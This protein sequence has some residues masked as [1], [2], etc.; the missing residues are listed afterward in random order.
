MTFAANNTMTVLPGPRIEVTDMSEKSAGDPDRDATGGAVVRRELFERLNRAGRVTVVSGPAGSGKSVL[1]RSWID[2]AALAE[3]AAQLSVLDED[4]DPQ[5][6]WTSVADA[7]RNTAAGS[8]LISP[9][10]AA[11]DLDGWAVVERL[12]AD[13]GPLRDRI[14]LVIDDVHALGSAETL[15]QFELL[16]MR[17]PAGLRFV[18]AT[19]HDL[20]L[21]LHR[22]RLEGELTE[23]RA[24]SLR[25]SRD[26][27]EALFEAAGVRLSESALALLHERTEGWA[28][29]LRLAV[30]SLTGHPDP[31]RFA[32]E[33]CGSE[34]TVAEYLLAEVLERQSD[35]VRRLLSRTSVLERVSGPL[36]DLLTGGSG[37]GQILQELEQAGAFVVALDARRSWFRYHRL[38]ADLLELELRHTEPAELAALHDTAADWFAGHGFPVEAVR[39]AQAAQDWE[40]AGHL[41]ADHWLDVTL[42]GQAATAHQLVASFPADAVTANAELTAVTAAVELMDGSL[43]EGARYLALATAGAASVP[44]ARRDR[45]RVTLAVLRVYLARQR[46]DLRAIAEEVE[47]LRSV[48]D[49]DAAQLGLGEELR[50]VALISLGIAELWSLQVDEAEAHLERGVALARRI[51]RPFLEIK[52]L[53][54]W[55]VAASFR[56]S[57]LAAERSRQAIELARRHGWSG[58]PVVAIAYPMLAGSL[59]WQGELDEAER[60]LMEGGYALKSEVE[61]ATEMLFQLVRGLLEI[62]RGHLEAAL[63]TLRAPRRLPGRP[64]SA[65]HPLTTEVRAFLLDVL[66]RLG[67]PAQADAV[68]IET[69]GEERER[70]GIRT[71]MAALRLAQDDPRAA[72]AALAPVLDGSA[73]GSHQV[74]QIAAFLLEASARDALGE[75]EAAGRALER[76]LDLAEPAGLLFPFLL[77]P[78]PELLERHARQRTAHPALI[79]KIISA[80]GGRTPAVPAAGPPEQA[81]PAAGPPQH[82]PEPLSQAEAR[83]LRLLQTSLSAPEIARELYV[84]VNTVRT[85]MRHVYDKLGAHRRLEA[86][87]R[88]RALGLLAVPQ[89]A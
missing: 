35:E 20:R 32:A 31:E 8:A 2:E 72:T 38:F 76:G 64:L 15:R 78:M 86:I 28:A 45:L 63:A 5:R 30:L 24:A 55:G 12:L 14:W 44:A 61:P 50:A 43:E 46:G 73:P 3:H 9:L 59:I 39:H 81:A 58:E 68:L 89:R 10:S 85:H 77:Y 62:A 19:R 75:R 11:P 23:I 74:W 70:P 49:L 48:D 54:H 18:L 13:L 56:S 79:R 1:L 69:V 4:R 27:A 47:Q 41:L 36:A 67:E 33:F 83:V 65:A 7:L 87:D 84:S 82:L 66:V 57:E 52:G 40:R 71:A 22:L 25:F 88:A 26:E 53:A 17:A 34:R 60:W 16:L 51:G 6:F 29:G 21:G 37:G 80:L 42:N